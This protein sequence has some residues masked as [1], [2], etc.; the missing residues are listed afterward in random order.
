MS[1]EIST[2]IFFEKEDMVGKIGNRDCV[3]IEVSYPW[4]HYLLVDKEELIRILK[5]C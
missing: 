5:V 1:Y 3:S 4:R 2:R